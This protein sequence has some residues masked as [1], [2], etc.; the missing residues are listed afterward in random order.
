MTLSVKGIPESYLEAARKFNGLAASNEVTIIHLV[1]YKSHLWDKWESNSIALRK[2]LP[3]KVKREF[4]YEDIV[5]NGSEIRF[6]TRED[7]TYFH[8]KYIEYK[9]NNNNG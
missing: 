8:L 7:M 5:A 4:D 1:M 6:R 2:E 3:L 9:A